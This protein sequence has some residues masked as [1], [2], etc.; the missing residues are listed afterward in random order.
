MTSRILL[1]CSTVPHTH[2]HIYIPVHKIIIYELSL[3]A[4]STIKF[5]LPPRQPTAIVL[6]KPLQWNHFLC[7]SIPQLDSTKI[8]PG[9]L[10]VWAEKSFPVCVCARQFFVHSIRQT[11][12]KLETQY[13]NGSCSKK[14]S[15]DTITIYHN[16]LMFSRNDLAQMQHPAT[17][18]KLPGPPALDEQSHQPMSRRK[19]KD[20]E[21]KRVK[22]Y[23]NNYWTDMALNQIAA[24]HAAKCQNILMKFEMV[25]QKLGTQSSKNPALSWKLC[26][27]V[28]CLKSSSFMTPI[29]LHPGYHLRS[30]LPL[31]SIK[32]VSVANDLLVERKQY[33]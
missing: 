13:G 16:H 3:S 10:N 18:P 9:V 32:H 11:L 26:L 8:H 25:L 24:K 28:Y 7:I 30:I 14:P 4:T 31:P 12:T 15:R 6:S 5:Y 2:N 19:A 29:G 1:R 27:G 23:I 20:G 17:W 22:P 33:M 21:G